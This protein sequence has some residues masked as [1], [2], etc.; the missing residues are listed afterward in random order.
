MKKKEK[1][2]FSVI[3]LVLLCLV[4]GGLVYNAINDVEKEEDP[5]EDVITGDELPED[6][7][8]KVLTLTIQGG[9]SGEQITIEYEEGMTW[10]EVI[11]LNNCDLTRIHRDVIYVGYQVIDPDT[12]VPGT[13]MFLCLD[14]AKV[15]AEDII[16]PNGTY[17]FGAGN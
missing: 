7:G 13:S 15:L 4:L 10:T 9:P 8:P 14:N 16:V 5:T 12:G 1:N 17:Y 3:A 11:E 6:E 2:V